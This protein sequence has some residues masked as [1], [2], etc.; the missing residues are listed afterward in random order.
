MRHRI[1][2][3]A[4][5]SLLACTGASHAVF[6]NGGFEQNNLT[7]WTVGGGSNPG[8]TGTPDRKSVV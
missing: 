8:L 4:A 1:R 7:G 3:I 5:A 6:V 2:L